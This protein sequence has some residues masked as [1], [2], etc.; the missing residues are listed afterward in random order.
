MNT[1]LA[2]LLTLF[3]VTSFSQKQLEFNQVK[4]VTASETVPADKVWKVVSVAA[5]SDLSIFS[6]F[7]GNTNATQTSSTQIIINGDVTY[8]QQF[9]RWTGQNV[10]SNA[11]PRPY[12]SEAFQVTELPIWLP[13]GT[14]L[15]AGLNVNR[16]SVI[17]FNI[18][19]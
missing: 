9:L 1:I 3:A 18:V 4:L 6:T 19:E 17:E 12:G 15:E 11:Q 2:I 13:A 10:G 16:I 8:M 7:L 14:T 5:S